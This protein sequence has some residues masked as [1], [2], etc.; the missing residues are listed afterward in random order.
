MCEAISIDDVEMNRHGLGV[1]L[2][3][4]E[5]G[6]TSGQPR[7]SGSCLLYDRESHGVFVMQHSGMFSHAL[8]DQS[9]EKGAS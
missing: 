9:S 1:S 6:S 7:W 5:Q 2:G 3:I 4:S 8:I